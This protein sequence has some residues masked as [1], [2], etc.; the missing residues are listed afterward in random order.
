MENK[1]LSVN[2]SQFI[3]YENDGAAKL[4]VRFCKDDVWLTQ[5]QIAELFDCSRTNIVEHIGNI[6]KEEELSDMATCRNFR[7]VQIEG[8]REVARELPHYNLDMIISLG[9]RIN[10]KIATQFRIWATKRLHEYIQKGFVVDKERLKNPDTPFDYF[11]ELEQIIQDIRTSERR[12]Y[13]KITDI[14]ATSV[15]YDKNANITKNF[16]ATVQNKL[17]WATSGQTAAEIIYGRADSDKD[18]MGLT[19]WR[20]QRIRKSD[21]AVAK[22]YL[23]KQELQA[24]NDLVEQYLVFAQTQARA[25]IPMTM[26]KWIEKLNGFLTLNDREILEHA[27]NISAKLAKEHAEAEYE[28]FRIKQA[29]IPYNTDFEEFAGLLEA[30]KRIL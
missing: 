1:E 18:N 2:N 20:G 14:Y 9:Y 11:E 5:Q 13:L 19:S 8:R 15:D 28:I 12:F 17:H 29:Q 27:G 4:D 16:F 24:L 22:N 30:A 23:E 26:Q 10:S 7:Q 25:R 21:V 3:I 6:Y